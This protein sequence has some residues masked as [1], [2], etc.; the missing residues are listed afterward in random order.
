LL[1]LI[2]SASASE[3]YRRPFT[4]AIFIPGV[5]PALKAGP[6]QI[7]SVTIPS[8]FTVRPMV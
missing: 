3:E 7:E 2:A 4:P 8:G 6:F 5:T 1:R